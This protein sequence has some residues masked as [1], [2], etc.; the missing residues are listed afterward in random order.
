[1]Q[2][3]FQPRFTAADS[4]PTW[5]FV[6]GYVNMMCGETPTDLRMEVPA[7]ISDFVGQNVT[8]T[9]TH[10]M[11]ATNA[12]YQFGQNARNLEDWLEMQRFVML[13]IK[14]DSYNAVDGV[15]SQFSGPLESLWLYR[16]LK[17]TIQD[18]FESL[19]TKMC[20]TSLLLN[21][22]DDAINSFMPLPASY[23]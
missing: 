16:K 14:A 2:L 18:T 4:D 22:R 20:K 7:P 11:A 1:L 10:R 21:I 12:T 17:S 15:T 9:E 8:L 5:I 6:K 19:V 23:R 3:L 13:G